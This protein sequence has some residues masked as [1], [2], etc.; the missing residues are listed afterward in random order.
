MIFSIYF[1]GETSDITKNVMKNELSVTVSVDNH[2][3]RCFY[4][5]Q[6]NSQEADNTS[7]AKINIKLNAN[8]PLYKI[9][10]SVEVQPPLIV[11]QPSNIVNS[12]SMK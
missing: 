11:T 1:S 7:M 2:F 6:F 12:L 8:V 5:T 4:P 10:I 3:E 9:K